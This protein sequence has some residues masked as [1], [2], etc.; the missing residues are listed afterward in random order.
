M[1]W[2]SLV[3]GLAQRIDPVFIILTV[4]IMQLLEML[5]KRQQDRSDLLLKLERLVQ[6]NANITKALSKIYTELQEA[7]SLI[8]SIRR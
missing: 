7:K 6:C 5:K 4:I 1:G 2:E 8:K 3:S